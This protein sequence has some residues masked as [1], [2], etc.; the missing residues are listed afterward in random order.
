[1]IETIEVW[2]KTPDCSEWMDLQDKAGKDPNLVFYTFEI[3]KG[4]DGITYYCLSLEYAVEF[5]FPYK[6]PLEPFIK[7]KEAE[8]LFQRVYNQI[9]IEKGLNR[10]SSKTGGL[11][12]IIERGGLKNRKPRYTP[13]KVYQDGKIVFLPPPTSLRSIDVFQRTRIFFK[14]ININPVNDESVTHTPEKKGGATLVEKILSKSPFLKALA[15]RFNLEVIRVGKI[16]DEERRYSEKEAIE[17]ITE[18]L[19]LPIKN[20]EKVFIDMVKSGTL[21]PMGDTG[22]YFIAGSTPF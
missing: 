14:E 9:E 15:E 3:W 2:F 8:A 1:M 12:E 17:T 7:D 21:E 11:L 18:R 16:L 6:K 4:T 22:Y 20:A 5:T 10:P 19:E 13:I